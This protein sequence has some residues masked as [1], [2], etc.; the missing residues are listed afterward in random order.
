M[1]TTPAA[2]VTLQSELSAYAHKVLLTH[3]GVLVL[4]LALVGFGVC[5][6]FSSYDKLLAHAEALQ[7]QFTQAQAQYS[8]SQKQLTDL[9]ATD[10]AE[11]AQ[12]S[13]QQAALVSQIA[14]RTTQAPSPVVTQA[15]APGAGSED[16]VLAFKSVLSLPNSSVD[17]KAMS[18]GTVDL[19]PT[20]A[21]QTL[22]LLEAGNLAQANLKDET[23]LYDLEVS[24][25][26]SLTKDLSQCVS[27]ETQA[28]TALADAQK[29]LAVYKKALH[30][31]R[32][33]KILGGVGRN[34]ERIGIAI[35]AFEAGRKL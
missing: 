2:P 4:I 18:D 14:Q 1:A 20:V 33:R 5:R 35:V 34:A 27:D 29:A 15:L 10:S 21:Q 24:Q 6:G 28:K 13:S 26:S 7:A 19:G 22:S 23:Q 25:N 8:A 11:R 9:L 17:P 32:F 31:S 16:L 30:R 12:E 3:L